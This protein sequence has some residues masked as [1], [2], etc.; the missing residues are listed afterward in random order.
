MHT[1]D[2]YII[3]KC[4]EGDQSA[5]GFLVDKY[6]G[7]VYAQAYSRLRNFHDAEDVAQ[8]VFIIAYRKLHTLRRWDSVMAWLYSITSNLCK[9]RIRSQS[10]RPDS[11]FIEDQDQGT[12][13]QPS[14]DHYQEASVFESINDAL[15]SLP[16]IHR[17][18]LSLHYL[19]GMKVMDMAKYLGMSPRTIARRLNDARLQL[20]KEVLA[21]MNTRFEEQRLSA[22]FTIRIVEMIKSIKINPISPIKAL[23]LGLSLAAGIIVAIL[24]MN[25]SFLNQSEFAT[26]YLSQGETKV[27]NVGEFPVDVIKVS[28]IAVMSNANSNGNGS[29]NVEPSQQNALFMAPQA[30][31]G[32]WTKKADMIEARVDFT[33]VNIDNTIYCMGGQKENFLATSSVEVYNFLD[34]SWSVKAS[35]NEPRLAFSAEAVDG[36]IYVFGG[37]SVAGDFA[38][39]TVEEYDPKNDKWIF[40]NNMPQANGLSGSAV[41]DGLIY[42]IGGY[43][44]GVVNSLVH[45][46]NPKIDKWEQKAPLPEPLC[47]GAAC[48]YNGKIYFMG[49]YTGN[50]SF[51]KKVFEYDPS[52]N[53]WIEKTELPT[54]RLVCTLCEVS[55]KIYVIGGHS[56]IGTLSEIDIYDPTTNSWVEKM[57]MP[58]P[59]SGLSSEVVDNKIY[60]IGGAGFNNWMGFPTNVSNKVDSISINDS[61][62]INPKD[63]LPST[64]GNI[65]SIND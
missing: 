43:S 41:L 45:A 21:M 2:G 39:I 48:A 35:M 14:I 61:S 31:D 57:N 28:D 53:Q 23:P 54:A 3:H 1:E 13:D 5:F 44:P 29:G 37:L 11:E 58:E 34:D 6:K 22:A 47:G 10:R 65:K 20:K 50:F 17:E 32:T 59:R 27:L 12:L 19:A 55:G 24:G 56:P 18:I 64:W 49:G 42:S 15:N 52:S 33:S 36:K 62:S 38:S 16:D 8:E 63:K 40:K 30:E 4:L 9:L 46:Y 7:S 26:S 25:P 51:S 60:I